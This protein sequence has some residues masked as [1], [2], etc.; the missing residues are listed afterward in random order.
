MAVHVQCQ[1]CG[2]WGITEN[3]AF[4]DAAAVCISAENEPEGSPEGS[5]CADH[6][7][8]E[9]HL[10]EAR[11]TGVSHC[12]PVTITVMGSDHPAGPGQ[13]VLLRG[14]S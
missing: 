4:P 1:G 10:G 5:C 14:A 12:R 8:L 9:H 2:A 6:E 13:G 7:S 11:R 3:H